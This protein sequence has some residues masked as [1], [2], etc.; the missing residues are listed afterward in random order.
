VQALR[1]FTTAVALA[2]LSVAP[3]AAQ[4]SAPNQ[5]RHLQPIARP[6]DQTRA[7]QTLA[8]G[9]AREHHAYPAAKD[10]GMQAAERA[11]TRTLG[12][13][14]HADWGS[15]DRQQAAGA[16]QAG[17]NGTFPVLPLLTAVGVTVLVAMAAKWRLRA[18]SRV[19]FPAIK[20]RDLIRQE[21][22][23]AQPA[24]ISSMTKEA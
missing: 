19:N 11:L 9:L 8:R 13:E 4:A 23:P 18:H 12:R 15:T 17:P 2:A 14:G 10:P 6:T 21:S 7:Q 3:A 20:G 1:R 16:H 5:D 24:A 22:P